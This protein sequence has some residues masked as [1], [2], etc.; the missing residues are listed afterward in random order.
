M[1]AKEAEGFVYCVSSLGVTGI[2][3]EITTDI[4]AMVEWLVKSKG[5]SMCGWIWHLDPGAGKE[6]GSHV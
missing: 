3:S 2:R 5:Y 4:G 6:D 1:I